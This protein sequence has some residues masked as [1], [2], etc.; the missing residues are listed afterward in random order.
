LFQFLQI[1]KTNI[2]IIQFAQEL[3]QK[4]QLNDLNKY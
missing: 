2:L 4:P 1:A 3:V